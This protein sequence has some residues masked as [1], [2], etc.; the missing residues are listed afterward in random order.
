MLRRPITLGNIIGIFTTQS[1]SERLY[2]VYHKV[3]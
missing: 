3:I 1:S 2:Y